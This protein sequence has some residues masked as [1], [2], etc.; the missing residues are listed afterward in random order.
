MINRILKKR[1]E[2][3]MYL[4]S[5]FLFIFAS[6]F[7]FTVL[8]VPAPHNI[9]GKI[10]T[11]SSNGVE[12]GVPVFINNTDNSNSTLVYTNAPPI[13]M[14]RGIY[15]ATILG[16]D[17]DSITVIAWNATHYGEN[18]SVLQPTTTTVNVI[19]NETRASEANVTILEPLNNTLKNKSIEFNV[20]ANITI[21]GNDGFDCNATI[22]FA[23]KNIVNISSGE[24]LIKNLNYVGRGTSRTVNWTVIG[25]NEGSTNITVSAGCR[26]ESRKLENLDS[27]SVY[28]ITIQNLAPIISNL[29][30]QQDIYL[31]P[32][33]NV[34]VFCNATVTDYNKATDIGAV[35]AT[36]YQESTG[37]NAADDKNFH[38]SNTSCINYS[39]SL[40]ESNYSCAFNV[41]YYANNGAWQC[42]LSVQ[43]NSNVTDHDTGLSLINELLAIDVSPGI[44][45]YGNLAATDTSAEDVNITI[46][47]FGNVDFNISLYG[48]GIEEGDNLSMN[49]E[50]RNISISNQRYSLSYNTPYDDMINLTNN[51]VQIP[52]LI[53]PQRTDDLNTGND[54]NKTYWK[55]KVPPLVSGVC[56]GSIVFRTIL[57]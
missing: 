46:S 19:L 31:T 13:P 33:A 2:L 22:S 7:S 27:Y 15:S 35:N 42:N 24:I 10:F 4:L 29:N 53:L 8:A 17:Y 5:L 49:C 16:E 56:N 11:N 9:E 48:F 30:L 23:D 50:K 44:I 47:N 21:M 3:K 32:G 1:S 28:N 52:D 18:F 57:I 51:S 12:N 14:L 43:D 37:S 20:T 40:F 36:F 26:D 41:A 39:S 45:N 38:Y 6:L 34:T 54:T 55:L 25:L